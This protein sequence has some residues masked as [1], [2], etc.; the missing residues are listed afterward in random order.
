MPL[1]LPS[2]IPQ[3]R[4]LPYG[5][6]EILE[7][8]AR[9][10]PEL[11]ALAHEVEAGTLTV[12]LARQQY[13]PDL[14]LS[15]SGDLGGMTKSVM[16]MLSGPVLR[17]E[18]IRASIRQARAEL[19]ASRAVRRQAGSDLKARAILMLYDLRDAE[20]RADL[21]GRTVIP[22]L[23]QTIDAER[24]G[25]QAGRSPLTNLLKAQR[26]LLD[27]RG[28]LAELRIE[29]EKLLAEIEEIAGTEAQATAE[30]ESEAGTK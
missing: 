30:V 28:M 8:V 11:Q 14:G 26:M 4:A 18:A 16:A 21:L 24:A 17:L 23:E 29:R 6:A 19:E 7:L 9:K 27:G 15:V 10:N 5:D 20:R 3:P 1:D 12:S 2:A 13:I 22:R 25:Y